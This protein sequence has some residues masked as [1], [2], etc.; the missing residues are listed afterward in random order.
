MPLTRIA[1]YLIR[2][3]DLEATRK[4]YTEVM[5]LTVGPRP[6]FKFPGLW[7]Q[8]RRGSQRER[9]EESDGLNFSAFLCVLSVPLK[10]VLK[11]ILCVRNFLLYPHPNE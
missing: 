7:L 4:F 5:S 11:G 9:Q 3:L 10:G 8:G 2:T 6:P 1:H